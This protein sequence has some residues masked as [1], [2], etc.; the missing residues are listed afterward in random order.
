MAC[1]KRLRP[2]RPESAAE[3]LANGSL[4]STPLRRGSRLSDRSS[5]LLSPAQGA[6][7]TVVIPARN[8]EERLPECLRRLRE[9]T[10][11]GFN[12]IVVD[13]ASTDRTGIVAGSCG[14]RVLR[15]DRP[16]VGLARQTGFDATERSLIV[17]TD[18]DALPA[19]DWLERL[20][21]PLRDPA[22]VCVF[23]TIRL[24]KRGIL[25][26]I[27]HGLFRAFQRV[28]LVLRRPICCGP[29]FAVRASAFRAVGGFA[30]GNALPNDAED[31][32]LAL[33][34]RAVGRV[35]YLPRLAMDV[36]AR[37][38]TGKR[39]FTY[40]AHNTRVYFRVCWFRRQLAASR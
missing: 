32:R 22:A 19:P 35:V 30:A 13:S 8:E 3:L 33:K 18:A 14:A 9:Q 10:L 5:P 17:S 37:S 27:G 1:V 15:V 7:I 21:A 4:P 16:G 40:L 2:T 38:L 6:D 34:L 29:N 28:N 39:A 31:V 11:Q 26:S 12:V 24:S 23:G 20:V 25:V 36:S